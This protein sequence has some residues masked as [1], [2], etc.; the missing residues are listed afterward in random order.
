MRGNKQPR[1]SSEDACKINIRARCTLAC[2]QVLLQADEIVA[3][4]CC[5]ERVDVVG[6][7]EAAMC[8]EDNRGVFVG[9]Q[10][11]RDC[12]VHPFRAEGGGCL[13]I[14]ADRWHELGHSHLSD[15]YSAV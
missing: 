4:T 15:L 9:A 7:L 6:A 2:L 14:H 13:P 8:E 5:T 1:P 3:P 10:I 12:R 11:E